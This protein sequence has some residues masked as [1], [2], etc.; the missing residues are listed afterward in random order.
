MYTRPDTNC[1]CSVRYLWLYFCTGR[2]NINFQPFLR[3]FL[4]TLFIPCGLSWI[5]SIDFD[6]STLKKCIFTF[7]NMKYT[8]IRVFKHMYLLEDYNKKKPNNVYPLSKSKI[9][10][11]RHF[12]NFLFAL[13]QFYLHSGQLF[14]C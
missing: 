5:H 9:K 7:L 6:V 10:Y 2:L 1:F 13:F 3:P 14:L 8:S 4:S 12:R 11:H